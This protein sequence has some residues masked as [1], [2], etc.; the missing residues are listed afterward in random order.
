[1]SRLGLA[2]VLLPTLALCGCGLLRGTVE[3]S[4][5]S[6]PALVRL[7]KTLF[8]DA[9]LS[10]RG[11]TSCGTCHRREHAFAEPRRFSTGQTGRAM[12]R[13]TPA[14]INRPA[15][16]FEFWDGR[17]LS[18]ADQAMHPLEEPDEMGR[19]IADACRRLERLRRYPPLFAD[20]FGWRAIT[21]ARLTAAIAAFVES[22]RIEAPRSSDP[23]VLRGEKLFR[24]KAGCA[25]CHTG[26]DFSDERF[27]NT[28]VAWK[29]GGDP[30]R[31]AISGLLEDTRA[32]KTPTLLELV[33]TAPYMHDGSLST[34]EAVV[35]HYEGGGAPA[36][37]RLDAVLKPVRLSSGERAD[38]L[39]FLRSLS[40]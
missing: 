5:R 15:V 16:G 12:R 37:P 32:F 39:A 21:P 2:A 34:L 20:A 8:F 4:E 13:H 40:H 10:E 7:G 29:S 11:N 14:L 27:H 23:V 24:G 26:P 31:A 9:A 22:L 33:R 36:D 30:G 25:L 18:L 28:G 1:M 38:L 3:R 17:A 6:R 19:S 35:R